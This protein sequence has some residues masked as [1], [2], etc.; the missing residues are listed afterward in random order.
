MNKVSFTAQKPFNA[1]K[2]H[3]IAPRW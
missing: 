2:E 3:H 1:H